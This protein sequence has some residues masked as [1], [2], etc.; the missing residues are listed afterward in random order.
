LAPS[1]I[2]FVADSSCS[3]DR[4]VVRN[5]TSIVARDFA[6][7]TVVAAARDDGPVEAQFLAK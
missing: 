6:G 1:P 4:T 2:R 5:I 3:F 7:A